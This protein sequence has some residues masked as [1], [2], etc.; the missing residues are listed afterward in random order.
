M[1]VRNLPKVFT[2]GSNLAGSRNS[3]L[4]YAIVRRSTITYNIRSFVKDCGGIMVIGESVFAFH[5][6]RIIIFLFKITNRSFRYAS[7]CLWNKLPASFRQPNP[8]HSFSHSSQP[9]CL[10]SSVSSSPLSLS[11]TPI[12]FS[13]LNSKDTFSLNPSRH[14]PH[15]SIGLYLYGHR[16]AQW[17]SF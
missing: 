2:R 9:N 1:G 12:L 7:P 8:D 10:S 13:T 15:P 3:H 16:T 6:S 11:I 17:F 4:R 5:S 14:R